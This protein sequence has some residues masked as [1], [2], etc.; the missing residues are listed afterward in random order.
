MKITRTVI[1][2]VSKFVIL[3]PVLTTCAVWVSVKENET[4]Y[5]TYTSFDISGKRKL[6]L[7]ILEILDAVFAR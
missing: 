2:H 1:L 3:Y 6:I 7:D 4:L 5:I